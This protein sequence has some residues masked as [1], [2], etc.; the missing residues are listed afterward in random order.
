MSAVAD[1]KEKAAVVAL[2]KATLFVAWLK[3]MPQ[4][5]D[6]TDNFGCAL[7]QY[8]RAKGIK[9]ARVFTDSVETYAHDDVIIPASIWRPMDRMLQ[10]YDL[11]DR[12]FGR[13]LASF[14]RKLKAS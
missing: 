6:Y 8:L 4:V 14:S 13:L 5:F 1:K 2:L 11:A 12:T 10:D 7:A 3:T 9:R